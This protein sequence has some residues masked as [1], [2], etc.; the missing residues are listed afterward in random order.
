MP[1][2]PV[3]NLYQWLEAAGCVVIEEDFE[4]PR[5]DGLSQWIDDVPILM[6]NSAAP[7][8]RR[9]MTAA[10]ELGQ[11]CL[12]SSGEIGDDPE[13]EATEF[14]AELLMPLDTIRPQLRNLNLGRLRI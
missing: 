13:R 11:L 6:L 9:R 12:H 3:R 4:V 2:G 8:D 1:S 7:V 10:H 5:V 14:A